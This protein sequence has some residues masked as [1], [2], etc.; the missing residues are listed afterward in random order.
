M[1]RHGMICQLQRLV[2]SLVSIFQASMT[3][4]ILADIDMATDNAGERLTTPAEYN[5]AEPLTV[6]AGPNEHWLFINGIGVEY[7]WL[8]L[9]CEKL[10]DKYGRK[11][12]GIFNR[13]G[14]LLWDLIECAGQR[15]DRLRGNTASQ[16]TLIQATKSSAVA[17]ET[18]YNRL[19]SILEKSEDSLGP[20]VMV[21]RSQGCLVLCLVLQ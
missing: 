9:A 11:V 18:L 17:Q 16:D 3:V 20:R 4:Q 21:A 15:S 6:K 13:G 12:V 7:P 5:R 19:K 14:G 10:E 1:N 8:R 2:K